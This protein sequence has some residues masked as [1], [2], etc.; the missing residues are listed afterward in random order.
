MGLGG[1]E[2]SQTS[3]SGYRC[4]LYRDFSFQCSSY[5]LKSQGSAELKGLQDEPKGVQ[6]P[7]AVSTLGFAGSRCVLFVGS[8]PFDLLP[9]VCGT[10]PSGRS[11]AARASTKPVGVQFRAQPDHPPWPAHARAAD[12]APTAV[13]SPDLLDFSE[14]ARRAA[15]TMTLQES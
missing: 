11:A 15:R 6:A 13:H 7:Q 12:P 1:V 14:L 3:R 5:P 4:A 8:G 9:G 2:M 10:V